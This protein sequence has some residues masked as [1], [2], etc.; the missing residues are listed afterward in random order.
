MQGANRYLKKVK[1]AE[2]NR[3]R[4]KQ[5]EANGENHW[6]PPETTKNH[7]KLMEINLHQ[8]DGNKQKVDFVIF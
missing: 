5:V 6:E 7:E 1:Q 4:W 8:S 3:N 2:T